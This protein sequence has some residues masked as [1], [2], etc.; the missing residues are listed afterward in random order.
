MENN[1]LDISKLTAKELKSLEEYIQNGIEEWTPWWKYTNKKQSL[2]VRQLE[3][4]E[5]VVMD[6][7]T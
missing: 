2:F 6:E 4:E 5:E 1:T 7:S 3:K